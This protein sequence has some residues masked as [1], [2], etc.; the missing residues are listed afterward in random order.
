MSDRPRVL[1]TDA[2]ERSM[3]AVC[4]SLHAA[5][6]ELTA[7]SSTALAPA[8]W[9]RSCSRRLRIINARDDADRFVEQLRQE[10]ARHSYTALIAGSDSALLAISQGREHLCELTEL[11][12][13]SPS[14]VERVLSRESLAEAAERAELAPAMSIRCVDLEQA[15]GAAHRLGFPVV[16][17]SAEAA[18]LSVGAVSGAPKGRLVQNEAELRREVPDFHAGLL[19]QP[20]VPGE[21]ISFAGVSAG[22]R[23]LAIAAARYI[24]MWPPSGGSV[25]F[26]ETIPVPPELEDRVL[27]LLTD[28]GWEGIFE[29][30]LIHTGAPGQSDFVPIDLNPRPYGSMTLATAAGAPLAAIWCDWLLRGGT[31]AAPDRPVR[32]RPGV[33]YRW[34]DG[35]LRHIWQELRD[36]RYWSALAPLRP[37]RGVVHAHFQSSDPLPLIVRGLYLCKRA[38]EAVVGS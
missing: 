17:K 10:L 29:L 4:R 24:R 6:Y 25:T 33:R 32:A 14:V 26:A 38:G 31:Q 21:P 7:A 37:R 2:D 11:G 23:L 18:V 3:L 35:E 30:E 22:G 16:L 12:L 28:L 8:K 5:G 13:P 1:I 20:V 9:S 27:Q 15:L 19:V 34:E 36:G